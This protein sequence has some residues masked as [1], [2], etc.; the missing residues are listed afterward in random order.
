MCLLVTKFRRASE[1]CCGIITGLSGV[2]APILLQIR[3]TVS[4]MG[5]ETFYL[6]YLY[7]RLCRL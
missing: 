2:T 1:L 6:R 5:W 7:Y 4:N 3:A